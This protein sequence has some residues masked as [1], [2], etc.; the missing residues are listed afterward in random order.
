MKTE[1]L[2][3]LLV[4]EIRDIYDAEKQLVK[5][6]P[7]MAKACDSE[8]LAEAIKD[9]LSETQNQ[10]SR[11]EQIFGLL[12]TPARGKSCKAMKG[13]LEEGTEALEEKDSGPIRDLAIIAAAQRVEHYEIS[14]YGTATALAAQV[15]NDE[16]VKL[17]QA[18][19]DEE[20]AADEKLTEV[21]M[22]IYEG[23]EDSDALEDEEGQPSMATSGSAS[24]ANSKRK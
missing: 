14:A 22:S 20:K 21:A 13:L 11:L 15:G 3:E 12:D 4:E 23:G 5:A 17:L 16:V 1:Q 18:T 2:N 10:V 8:D 19:A 6:L 7:K 9:H 24:R